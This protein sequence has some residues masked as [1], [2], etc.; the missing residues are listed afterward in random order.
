MAKMTIDELKVHVIVAGLKDSVTKEKVFEKESVDPA[1]LLKLLQHLDANSKKMETPRVCTVATGR[2][3]NRP[4]NRPGGR[5][6]GQIGGQTRGP[7]RSKPG[8]TRRYSRNPNSKPPTHFIPGTDCCVDC[9]FSLHTSGQCPARGRS[10]DNCGKPGHFVVVCK[11]APASVPHRPACSSLPQRSAPRDRGQLRAVRRID[12]FVNILPGDEDLEAEEDVLSELGY[13]C[14]LYTS[15]S[16][17][18]KRQS[19]M[20]SS[21]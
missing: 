15:P 11:S 2:P 3:G 13:S 21:A 18:D 16:P 9:G 7:G 6:G 1:S 10:C 17:R 20:P 12:N 19:R 5:S 8:E 14:L 4:G